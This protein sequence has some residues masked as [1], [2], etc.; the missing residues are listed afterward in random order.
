M[1]MKAP[2]PLELQACEVEVTRLENIIRIIVGCALCRG[3]GNLVWFKEGKPKWQTC[4]CCD[5]H[6][7]KQVMGPAEIPMHAF[8]PSK[9]RKK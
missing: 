4:P 2:K 5:G 8:K 1:S 7:T 9:W 3:T 6:G